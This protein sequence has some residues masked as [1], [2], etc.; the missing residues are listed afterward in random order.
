MFENVL[1]QPAVHQLILDLQNSS[2][3]PS[4]LFEGPPASGKGTTAL[5]LGRTLSC[6]TEGAPWNCTCSECVKHRHLHHPDLLL[7]GSRAFSAEIAAASAAY[8]RDSE[9]AAKLLFFRSVRKLLHRFNPLLWEGEES[10]LTKLAPII[11]QCN[12]FIEE[13]S[14]F[15]VDVQE[16]E[17]LTATIVKNAFQLEREG[18]SDTIPIFQIRRSAYWARLAPSGRR[19]LLVIENADRMQDAARNALLKILEEPPESCQIVMCTTKK[20]ALLPTIRSRLR[21][22]AFEQRNLQT[23]LEIIRRVF[24]DTN[25]QEV[26]TTSSILETYLESFLPISSEHITRTAGLF[27]FALIQKAR[28]ARRV[29]HEEILVILQNFSHHLPGFEGIEN[30]SVRSILLI[31]M[32]ELDNFSMSLLFT[33]FLKEVAAFCSQLLMQYHTKPELTALISMWK[34]QIKEAD[35]AVSTYNLSPLS[36]LERLFIS[37]MEAI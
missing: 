1:G 30:A 8:L 21:S 12:E 2:L 17:K 19:K 3:P 29:Q 37:M 13:L 24:K 34:D 14:S 28:Q 27:M 35:N 6:L 22:Y 25:N 33:D 26:T 32:K 15:Q 11:T 23:E 4:I 5:E 7:L 18:I 10:R 36:S 16:R 31:L 9:S 20:S